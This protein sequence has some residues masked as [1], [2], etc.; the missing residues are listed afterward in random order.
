MRSF[1]LFLA[2]LIVFAGSIGFGTASPGADDFQSAVHQP[3]DLALK[4][5]EPVRVIRTAQQ[6]SVNAALQDFLSGHRGDIDPAALQAADRCR[7]FASR[8]SA[9]IGRHDVSSIAHAIASARG[10]PHGLH[11]AA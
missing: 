7:Q 1:S 9:S 6:A 3:I 8:S 4:G 2:F 5:S 11:P 10:P